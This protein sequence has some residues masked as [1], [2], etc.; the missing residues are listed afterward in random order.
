MK[1]G[2][3]NCKDM[4][5][6]LIHESKRL[7]E[8]WNDYDI[9]NYLVTAWHLQNDWLEKDRS[10]P[11]FALRK[12]GKAPTGMKE[13][14]SIAKEITNGSKHFSIKENKKAKY[15][16]EKVHDPEIRDWHSYFIS[17]PKYG[18]STSNAYYSIADLV[19]CI[20]QYF[21]WVFNEELTIEAFPEII[22]KTI[23]RCRL[24]V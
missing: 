2:I 22:L 16:V 5:S 7:H 19:G 9:F 10:A 21:E 23:I 4:Y 11:N 6:K 18:V 1:F 13:I 15:I 8:T 17:G 24:S 20:D 12:V 14:M 3:K